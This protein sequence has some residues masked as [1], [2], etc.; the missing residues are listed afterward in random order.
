[1]AARI[2]I[3]AARRALWH[4][5]HGGFGGLGTH[6]RRRRAIDHQLVSR[7]QGAR[8]LVA[9]DPERFT[10][11]TRRRALRVAVILDEFSA[12]SFDFEW[13][14]VPLTMKRWRKELETADVDLLF[15]ESAWAGNGASW[16]YQLT[17]PGGP[18][19]PLKDL[20]THC[21]SRGIPTVFWNKEDPVHHEDFLDA[22]RLFDHVLTTDSS[23]LEDYRS[24]LGHD[25][26]GVLPFSAQPALHNPVRSE[27][28]AVLG[29]MA[30]GGMYFTHRHPGR[31]T[32][33]DML[34]GAAVRVSERTGST[35]D[36]YSRQP[37][38]DP[39]YQFPAPMAQH[40]VGT[41]SYPQMLSA[42]RAY[43]VFLNVNTVALSP[44]M[45]ARR[46]V[47]ITACGTPVVSTPSPAIDAVLGEDGVVQV[48]E[49][50]EA[51]DAL[52]ALLG[53][54]ELRDRTVHRAQR[55]IWAGHTASHRVDEI[56]R[57][58]GLTEH[59]REARTPR[60]TALVSTIRPER[61]DLVLETLGSQVGVE[62]Q[63]A[64][65]AHGWDLDEAD[66]RRRAR[67][68]GLD[69]VVVLS[70]D[71]SVALG[72]CL[73]RLV[74]VA[75]G[76]VVAKIDDDDLYGPQYLLDQVNA[77]G[78]SGADV[79]GKQAHYVHL[80]TSGLTAL[81]HAD[82]EHHFTDLVTG[83]SIVAGTDLVRDIPFAE[84]TRGEDTGFLRAVT[85]AGCHIYSADRFNFVQVR[86]A[87]AHTWNASDMEILASSQVQVVG[88]PLPH[89]LA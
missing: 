54:S 62:V 42:Y 15:V 16:K 52:R 43:K 33:M 50:P 22:A 63:L 80:V 2:R 8:G 58:V 68:H 14:Q 83:P 74:E 7:R 26:V 72:T 35:L 3:R 32:Q 36:I 4:L 67:D 21:Q 84:L 87:T 73:N 47:E 27:G 53:S 45:C 31:A 6:L 82:R 86:G 85:A 12:A 34:L 11:N 69:D 76:A 19:Q 89:A 44:T 24:A 66:L 10:T 46:I 49:Q 9:Y 13:V 71:R 81:R 48:S 23:T 64:L 79:V 57:R 39:R 40:V 5:R 77:L 56:L 1:M 51:E 38:G 88:P 17:G 37:K 70:A 18:G 61:V 65:L 60:V 30:F 59:L 20:V 41:L 78:Y 75:D 29:D 28:D 25:R 55:R